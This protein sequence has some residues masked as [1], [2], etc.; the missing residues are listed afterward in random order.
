MADDPSIHAAR[1]FALWTEHLATMLKCPYADAAAF[2]IK[3]TPLVTLMQDPDFC[4][5]LDRYVKAVAVKVPKAKTKTDEGAT[6]Q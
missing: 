5:K 6:I 3:L 2:A 4:D 1:V